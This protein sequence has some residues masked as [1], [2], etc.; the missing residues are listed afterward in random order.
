LIVVLNR[1]LCKARALEAIDPD[2]HG[3]LKKC[4]VEQLQGLDGET[5]VLATYITQGLDGE[6]EVLGT[7][8]SSIIL[9]HLECNV[10][11]PRGYCK[12]LSLSGP[13]V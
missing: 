11:L 6:T 8:N 13:S 1:P 12:K 10:L 3:K 7:Y 5:A 9:P 4:R 2:F